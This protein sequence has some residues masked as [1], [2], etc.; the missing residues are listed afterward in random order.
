MQIHFKITYF[1]H[2]VFAFGYTPQKLMSQELDILPTLTFL[3]FM[4]S[5]CALIE[6]KC[7]KSIIKVIPNKSL[8]QNSIKKNYESVLQKPI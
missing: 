4:L 6:R 8:I 1:F 3:T 7:Q 2:A 5:I